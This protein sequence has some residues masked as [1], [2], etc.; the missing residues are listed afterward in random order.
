MSTLIIAA[1]GQNARPGQPSGEG[2]LMS[3]RSAAGFRASK[4]C[5][6]WPT[7]SPFWPE[8]NG[9]VLQEYC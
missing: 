1:K 6:N 3:R 5:G 8:I 9:L 7:P 4:V 2:A